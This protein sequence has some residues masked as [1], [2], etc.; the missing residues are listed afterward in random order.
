MKSKII[1]LDRDGVIN[2]D[3]VDYIKSP[4]E[5][6]PIEGSLEAIAILNQAGFTVVI[7]TNQ[8]G[9]A[10]G[11]YDLAAM[12]AIHLKMQQALF[13]V[14]GKIDKIFYC[15]HGPLDGCDC[16]KPKP[17]LLT[18]IAQFYQISLEQVPFVGDSMRDIQAARAGGAKPVLVLSGNG[19]ETKQ[20]YAEELVP[21]PCFQDLLAFAKYFCQHS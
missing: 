21:I 17:G 3:S 1:I 16:R 12:E 5:W 10:R 11:L 18:Q 20:R 15:P 19:L 2:H 7:A 14:G 9:I 4:A 8:S 6:F 13:Q